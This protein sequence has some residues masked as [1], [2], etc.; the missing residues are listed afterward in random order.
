MGSYRDR[1][2]W[3]KY[4]DS[5]VKLQIIPGQDCSKQTSNPSYSW[6]HRETYTSRGSAQPLSR[7]DL[8]AAENGRVNFYVFPIEHSSD[9]AHFL[10]DYIWGTE[11]AWRSFLRERDQP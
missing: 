10:V 3:P 6:T 7:F 5:G 9:E 4:E 1:S 8:A 2:R 11:P